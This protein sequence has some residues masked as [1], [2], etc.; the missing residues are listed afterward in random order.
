MKVALNTVKLKNALNYTSKIAISNKKSG[1]SP[2]YSQVQLEFKDKNLI[3]TAYDSTY[4]I[5]ID[6]GQ[7]DCE[8]CSYL[9]DADGIFNV[10]K[11]SDSENLVFDFKE[12]RVHVQDRTSSYKFNYFLSESKLDYVFERIEDLKD[13]ILVLKIEDFSRIRKFLDPCIAKDAAR[14]FLNGIHFDGNFVATDSNICGVYSY[15][16]TQKDSIFFVS[17]GLDLIT[18]LPSDKEVSFYKSNNLNVV[19]CENIRI[20]TPQMVGS[21]PNYGKMID[22]TSDYPYA[23]SI[24]R[25]KLLKVCR[26]LLPFADI[27]QRLVATA[28][29]SKEGVFSLSAAS[30]GTKEGF[31]TLE[32]IESI[33]SEED[34]TFHL[35]LR[36]LAD[37]VDSIPCEVLKIRY[38]DNAKTPL[39]ITDSD[40]C[41]HFLS[42]YSFVQN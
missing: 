10:A 15:R 16:D 34:I 39:I 20:L 4:G 24:E 13:P 17:E 26:K 11:Y 22:L 27:H 29:F 33:S 12:T 5:Q 2:L 35:N 42:V 41:N 23:F 36:Y 37:L 14:P 28:V 8:D 6:Y 21:F 3:L 7:V 31:E 30:E 18:S 40:R 32:S 25:S 1:S 38:S 9:I 19:I